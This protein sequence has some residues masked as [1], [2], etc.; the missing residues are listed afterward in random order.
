[1]IITCIHC[2]KKAT[3]RDLGPEF[4]YKKVYTFFL[5]QIYLPLQ[6][7]FQSKRIRTERTYTYTSR[8]PDRE[9]SYNWLNWLNWIAIQFS[10][11]LQS[12]RSD[13]RSDFAS[14]NE[15]RMWINLGKQ[16]QLRWRRKFHTKTCKDTLIPG[17][18][19]RIFRDRCR[20]DNAFACVAAFGVANQTCPLPNRTLKLVQM[21]E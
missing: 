5:K 10:E 18:E 11:R 2:R 8:R 19:L 16:T 6:R 12:E 4:S 9:F 1:M 17:L 21:L 20:R 15:M 13:F 3:A 14:E 7:S